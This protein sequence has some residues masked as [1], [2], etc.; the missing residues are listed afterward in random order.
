M[1][2]L[3]FLLPFI[4]LGCEGF[5]DCPDCPD[6]FDDPEGYGYLEV[7]NN[8]E[9]GNFLLVRN[10]GLEGFEDTLVNFWFMVDTERTFYLPEYTYRILFLVDSIQVVSMKVIIVNNE[11]TVRVFKALP[12]GSAKSES[13]SVEFSISDWPRFETIIEGGDY[14]LDS[15]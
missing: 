3:L 4:L 14:N 12:S 7:Q 2:K 1:R 15:I 5:F 11:T 10:Y 6:V 13:S 9:D 8:R